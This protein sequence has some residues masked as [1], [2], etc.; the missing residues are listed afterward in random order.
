VTVRLGN[1]DGTFAPVRAYE[2]GANPDGVALAD[3]NRDGKLDLTVTNNASDNVSIFLGAGDGTF[4]AQAQHPMTGGPETVVVAD[5]DAD[6]IPDI[7]T[8]SATFAPAV[9]TG[10]GDGTFRKSRALDWLYGQGGA[11]ADFNLDGRADLAFTDYQ[12]PEATVY[13]NWMGLPA[14]PC[15]VLDFSNERLRSAKRY[16]R[17]GGCKLGRVLHRHSRSVRKGRT[18]GPRPAIGTVLPSG[19]R[20]DIV[21][22]RGR[23]HRM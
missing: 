21:I 15:V 9:A 23:H 12:Q 2:A 3:L 10:R 4:G 18:I 11:V 13:L 17:D 20:V 19:S 22:S 7:A 1:G 14:P 5:F 8:S 16:V 6:G